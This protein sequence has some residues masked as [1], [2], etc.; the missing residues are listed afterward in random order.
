ML[1]NSVTT[2]ATVESNPAPGGVALVNHYMTTR[3]GD[4]TDLVELAKVVQR[5][6]ESVRA[7]AS[8]KLTVIAEQIRYLQEQAKKAL[9]EAKRDNDL[10]HAACNMVKRPG[11]I[12][13]MYE[14]ESGQK[15][16]SILSPQEWGS[17]CPHEYHGAFK[18][19]YDYSWTPFEDVPKREENDALINK[20]INAKYALP[21]CTKPNF[22]GIRKSQP[23]IEQIDDEK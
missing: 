11:T 20:I 16:L 23:E 7:N 8:N 2:V 5:A 1:E 3:H 22:E 12:Y 4:P 18:L 17:S 13:H 6:D 19:N 14:K 9:T 21:D 15:Y 10:H